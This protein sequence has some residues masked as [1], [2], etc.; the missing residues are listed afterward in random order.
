[1]NWDQIAGKWQEVKGKVRQKWG[2]LTDDDMA[3]VKGKREELAGV[4]QKRYG[5]AKEDADKQIDEF[6]KTCK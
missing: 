5:I 2:D 4:I 3:K 1:M 6:C